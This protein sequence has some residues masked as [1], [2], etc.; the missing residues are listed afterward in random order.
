MLKFQD[1]NSDFTANHYEHAYDI[2][3]DYENVDDRGG[4]NKENAN[5]GNNDYQEGRNVA[6]SDYILEMEKGKLQNP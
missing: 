5:N 2:G 1:N 4:D 6:L 3:G